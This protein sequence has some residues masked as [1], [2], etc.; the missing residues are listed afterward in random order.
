MDID[1]VDPSLREAARRAPAFRLESRLGLWSA[2]TLTRL[3]PGRTVEGVRRRIERHDGIRLRVYTPPSTSGAGLLWIHGGGL[4]IGSAA[5]DDVPCGKTARDTGAVVVSVDYRLAPRHP[6]PAAIDDAAAAF[7]WLLASASEL[8]VDPAR[9]AI[10]GQSAGGGLAAAL[11]QRLHDEGTQVS[12]QWLFCPMLDDRTAARRDLDAE[13]HLV[14]SN[15]ANR[16]G[17][18]SYLGDRVGADELPPYAAAARRTDLA[19]LPRTWLYSSDI[20][21]FYDEDRR[22]AER[23]RSAG[24]DVTFETVRGA[25]HGFEAWAPGSEMARALFRS[26]RDWLRDA[27]EPG[28]R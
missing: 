19:G 2:A 14:W 27:L 26:A 7:A 20:E 6:F 18:T 17:W 28:E 10:G 24:V 13:D 16:V 4:V 22:Y 9:I 3:A 11:V 23:L 5:I 21:L 12:A 1:V 15:R 8:G 25:P